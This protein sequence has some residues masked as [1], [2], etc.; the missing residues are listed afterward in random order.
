M[1]HCVRDLTHAQGENHTN[2]TKHVLKKKNHDAYTYL[3]TYF[4]RLLNLAV[5]V[6]KAAMQQITI[7]QPV[8]STPSNRM[9][10]TP[11]HQFKESPLM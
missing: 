5:H 4:L 3:Y 2:H 10:T 7:T 9:T 8:V 1:L 11:Q 6:G